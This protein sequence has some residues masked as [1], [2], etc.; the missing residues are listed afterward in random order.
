MRVMGIRSL[1]GTLSCLKMGFE[2]PASIEPSSTNA[3]SLND[4][5][6]KNEDSSNRQAIGRDATNIDVIV[7]NSFEPDVPTPV[8]SIE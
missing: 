7:G 3:K 1:S 4:L 2:I 5:P 8:Y 6:K